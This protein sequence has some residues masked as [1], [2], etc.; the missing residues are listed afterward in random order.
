MKKLLA[1]ILAALLATCFVACGKDDTTPNTNQNQN[2]NDIQEELII[3]HEAYDLTYSANEE[4][5]YEITGIIHDGKTALNVEIPA[6]YDNRPIVGIADEAFK[7]CKNLTAITIPASV[8]VI[9]KAAFYDCDGLVTVAIP[10]SVTVI[11]TLAFGD[12][13]ALASVNIQDG[14]TTIEDFAFRNCP[15]LVGVTLPKTLTAIGAGAF[16]NCDSLTSVTIPTSVNAIGDMAF[17][18]CAKLAAV[19]AYGNP[20]AENLGQFIFSN[21]ASNMILNVTP[22]SSLEAYAQA[23]DYATTVTDP[24]DPSAPDW[25]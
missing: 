2:N 12:C 22:G 24:S 6:N 9:G 14:L 5:D 17:S 4:G 1:I 19:Y 21:N 23:N 20:A 11:E 25:Q 10:A 18:E 8:T 16:R 15:A 13:N 7:A 3:D